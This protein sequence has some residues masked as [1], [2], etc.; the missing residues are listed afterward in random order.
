M[1]LC[2]SLL[3]PDVPLQFAAH[4]HCGRFGERGERPA[5]HGNSLTSRCQKS[6][7]YTRTGAPRVKRTTVSAGMTT[8]FLPV[9]AAPI[10]PAAAPAP[11]PMAAPTPPP[12]M[13]PI[14]APVPALPPIAARL[15]FLCELLT[16][17]AAVVAM[18]YRWPSRSN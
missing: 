9:T 5:A 4:A 7:I 17:D 6:A 10:V 1:D 3:H 2:A 15:R 12:A 8:C 16:R 13:A 14:A 18:G 11:A